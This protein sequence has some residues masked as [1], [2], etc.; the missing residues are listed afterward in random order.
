MAFLDEGE[1]EERFKQVVR[2][3]PEDRIVDFK[4]VWR[5]PLKTWRGKNG[6]SIVI[7]DAAHTHLP[8]SGQGA[9]QSMEDGAVI[10]ICLERANGNVPLALE[11]FERIRYNRQLVIQMT[12]ITNRDEYHHVEW[13][14]EFIKEHPNALVLRR[15]DWILEFDAKQ[16]A[17]DN[18]SKIVEEIKKGKQGSLRELAIPA[19]GVIMKIS[20]GDEMERPVEI[21]VA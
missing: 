2:Y 19:G 14:P 17:E 7:G 1:F 10:A 4:L 6:R 18:F 9:S 20:P 12:S 11:V 13:T 5:E 16:D 15:P 8:T 21:E 3:T